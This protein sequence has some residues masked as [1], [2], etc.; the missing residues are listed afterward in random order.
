MIVFN[1]QL[2]LSFENCQELGVNRFCLC[3][4]WNIQ[5]L[6]HD[7]ASGSLKLVKCGKAPII[8]DGT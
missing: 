8:T 5:R 7:V 2:A 3:G 1:W 6:A 4:K